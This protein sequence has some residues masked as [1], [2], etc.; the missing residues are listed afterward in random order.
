MKRFFFLFIL[1]SLCM[2]TSTSTANK[3][4]CQNLNDFEDFISQLDGDL[5]AS[6]R[7]IWEEVKKEL[8]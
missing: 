2:L 1:T 7:V 8:D 3:C 6:V 5:Q 4:L